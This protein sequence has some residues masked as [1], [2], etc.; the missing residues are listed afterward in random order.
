[1]FLAAAALVLQFPLFSA[2]QAPAKVDAPVAVSQTA[3]DSADAKQ[4]RSVPSDKQ[5]AHNQIL[6]A[7]ARLDPVAYAP[8]RLVPEP[9]AAATPLV[10]TPNPVTPVSAEPLP[11]VPVYA[12]MRDGSERWRR[13]EWMALS[14]AAHGT[15][16][17][18]AWSTRH[19]LSSMPNAVEANPLL[20]PFAGNASMYA[21]VQIAPTVLDFVSRRMMNSQ[22]A[23]MRHTWWLPQTV[24]AV[25]SL[26][27][28]VHN[29][30]VYNSR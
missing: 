25:V 11:I 18:D 28:G 3:A 9:V 10:A 23:W 6:A 14:I 21:A 7:D 13:R 1:M 24:S 30:G 5:V 4:E 12:P 29:L 20:R 22:H 2:V 26:S 8:G 19:V 17:F 15:A 27:S 16:T